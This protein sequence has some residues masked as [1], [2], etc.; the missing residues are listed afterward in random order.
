MNYNTIS[1][2]LLAVVL[3][4]TVVS[5]L[6]CINYAEAAE[7]DTV[8]IAQLVDET[9]KEHVVIK[10][11]EFEI[12]DENDLLNQLE[13]I[14]NSSVAGNYAEA[15]TAF[16]LIRTNINKTN[17][18]LNNGSAF[19]LSDGAIIDKNDDSLRLQGGS[20]YDIKYYWGVRRYMSTSQASYT[21]NELNKLSGTSSFFAV[22]FGVVSAEAGGIGAVPFAGIAL[23]CYWVASDV[24]YINSQTSNGIIL[25]VHYTFYYEVK[26]QSGYSGSLSGDGRSHSSGGGSF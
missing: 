15:I 18:D 19:L 20:S 25:D 14:N 12:I 2:K 3:I 22:V 9:I 8:N 7:S 1:R 5:S 21:A 24:G 4:C 6:G 13:K 23:Y 26:A 10:N 11:N 16:N 17:N